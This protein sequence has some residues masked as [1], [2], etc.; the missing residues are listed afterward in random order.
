MSGDGNLFGTFR[1]E[2]R[3]LSQYLTRVNGIDR[4]LRHPSGLDLSK[5]DDELVEE[6]VDEFM[7]STEP[8]WLISDFENE[9]ERLPHFHQQ[10]DRYVL[11]ARIA[12]AAVLVDQWPDKI[13]NVANLAYDPKLQEH[14]WHAPPSRWDRRGEVLRFTLYLDVLHDGSVDPEA[15]EILTREADRASRIVDAVAEQA[16]HERESVLERVR[17]TVGR[18]RGDISDANA[19]LPFKRSNPVPQLTEN[20]TESENPKPMKATTDN[21]PLVFVSH[22]SAD[23]QSFVRELVERL[24]RNGVDAWLDEQQLLAGDTLPELPERIAESSAIVIVLSE[25]ALE[26]PWV[27]SEITTAVYQHVEYEKRLIP[28]LL[29]GLQTHRIPAPLQALLHVAVQ[30]SESGK[31]STVEL[32][33]VVEEVVRA[34]FEVPKVA[35]HPVGSPPDYITEQVQDPTPAELELDHTEREVLKEIGESVVRTGRKSVS[36]EAL[37]SR[38]TRD[39]DVPDAKILEALEILDGLSYIEITRSMTSDPI[40]Q[41]G[42][43]KVLPK[44]MVW[45][46]KL[47]VPES[48]ALER[49]IYAALIEGGPQG[50]FRKIIDQTSVPSSLV[51]L[52]AD[53]LEKG[54]VLL[55]SKSLGPSRYYNVKS[56]PLLKKWAR[57]PNILTGNA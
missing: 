6:L 2:A 50:D 31:V 16:R 44:G 12:G 8:P 9:H 49:K 56:M 29:G 10:M 14:A 36:A 55:V 38:S 52:I 46:F 17:E 22:A 25:A 27:K 53:L 35:S 34:V 57:N 13:P 42:T 48:E 54:N 21:P 30:V 45:Y 51:D 4:R 39:F 20:P 5:S 11:L 19:L 3:T 43:F 15:T 28:I 41:I 33:R 7:A 32:D 26:R 23:K 47:F 1:S 40:K 37:V 18:I 24:R